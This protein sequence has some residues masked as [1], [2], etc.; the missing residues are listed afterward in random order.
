MFSLF[1]IRRP[2]FATV[3]SLLIVFAGAAAYM[4][5]PVSQYP[6]ITP[7]V[8]HV[9]ARYPG[10]DASVLARS[11]AQVLEEQINGV[12]GM[13]YMTSTSNSD[14]SYSCDITFDLGTDVDI[15]SV[16]VQNRVATAL[17]RLPQ[18][19]QR[20][21]VTTTK[22]STGIVLVM[23]LAPDK[24]EDA[25]EFDDTYLANFVNTNVRDKLSRVP[26]VG[27]VRVL[28]S[29]DY[30]MRVWIDPQ[31]LKARELA[32]TDIT[33]A[34]REQNVQV[35]A[36][37]VGQPP[38]PSGQN[39]QYILTTLGRLE[40][41][42]Q[43]RNIIVKTGQGGRITRLGEVAT[44]ELGARSY[45]TS[46]RLNG[47]PSAT[48]I[49]FQQPGA[50]AVEIASECRATLDNLKAI[51][52]IPPQLSSFAIYDV[53]EFVE[54][55]IS[56]VYKT[57]F[58]AIALVVIVVLVFLGN[59]RATLIPLITIP[60]SL[61]GTFAIMSMFGFSINLL[62]LFAL[63]LA[64]GIVV[65]DAIVVVENVERNMSSFHL[66][67][68]EATVRA[69]SEVSGP[70]I[71]ISLVLMSVFGPAALM[72]GITGELYRQFAL[73]IAAS[74]LLSAINALTLS[75]A[76]AAILLKSHAPNHR[77]FLFNRL[78]NAGFGW[79]TDRY[80]SV[81][82]M[83]VRFW[84]ASM[85]GFVLIL[86]ATYFTINRVPTAFL[87]LEDNGFFV[88]NIQLPD[89]ASLERTE[90]VVAR[91][92][93]ILN[94]TDGVKYNTALPGFSIIAG[95]GSNVAT[96]FATLTP[97]DDRLGRGRDIT[98]IRDEVQG[99][100][101]GVQE[102]SAFTFQFPP[103]PGLGASVGFD[104][105]L[106]ANDSVDRDQIQN[107]SLQMMGMAKE[108]LRLRNVFIPFRSGVPQYYIDIDRDKV[109]RL[110]IPLQRV[111]DTLQASMGS[112]Y[113]NDFNK[114]GRTW[115][116]NV[117][118]ESASRASMDDVLRLQ[119]S[120]PNGMVPM[121][122]IATIKPTF[123]PERIT[124]YNQ[125]NSANVQGEA[126]IGASSSE[127]MAAMQEIFDKVKVPGMT[128]EWSSISYQE[129]KSGGQASLV[130][131]AGIFV[132]YL[133]LAAQ[134]ESWS[135]P[136]SVAMSIPLSIIG[137]MLFL[138]V[139][140]YDNNIFTQIGLVLLVGLA[141]KNAI[142]IVEFARSARE[143]GKSI[144]DAAVE[145]AVTR[146]RP[147]LMTSFA[148]ILGCV[149]LMLASGAGANGRKAIGTAVVGGMLGATI[150]GVLFIP[151]LYY[152]VQTMA[153]KMSS[154]IR[155]R[156]TQHASDAE[157]AAH[158]GA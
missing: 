134:Y 28:P 60:V 116:V 26:G 93:E 44:V 152:I 49:I 99:K 128:N 153:E 69:M 75:P 53:A 145:A 122:S 98:T 25:K 132:V 12:E 22:Q 103:I 35:A 124:R 56:E 136:I 67:P 65:D 74:T 87:P 90:A 62:T 37:Q 8:I 32:T 2:I 109:K 150:L 143:S 84:P 64:I 147:I 91:V 6:E 157:A 7:P 156:Q 79:V 33:E 20:Q 72:G 106:L 57:I 38:A 47:R 21:G 121:G 154:G 71:A 144:R 17:P 138:M 66:A 120:G 43:F 77:P 85:A 14:G 36:G 11:V 95:N 142:L 141:A 137:A 115:Q 63:I 129:R 68:R 125:E 114:F 117:Q 78:F 123:G 73:T 83:L 101:M 140:G 86:G 52:T 104:M 58:E 82:S 105:R 5:L 15:A 94:N 29:K 1:F 45:D 55:T 155:N 126:G 24:L 31:K 50:N 54:Q 89:A 40:S 18:E 13:I 59:W 61:I 46:S 42:E 119:I 48:I 81:V 146:F 111:F 148:F 133:I 135:L 80:R 100:L 158:G 16:L 41:E 27:T 19:V 113:V 96:I 76:M 110:G 97:W 130:F 4:G 92:T 118:A 23:S 51:G 70:I 34:L 149:P 127:A 108:D 102:A 88:T 151:V 112:A 30:S 131:A 39:F 3:I 107:V 9:E 10:A 139:R